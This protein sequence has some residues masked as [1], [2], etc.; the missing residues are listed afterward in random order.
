[1]V[2]HSAVQASAWGTPTLAHIMTKL[3]RHAEH[4]EVEGFMV[5]GT[6]RI[7]MS[8]PYQHSQADV[9]VICLEG[10]LVAGGLATAVAWMC[11]LEVGP[12]GPGSSHLEDP[13]RSRI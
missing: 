10:R 6:V 1:M 12:P 9:A 13:G 4:S 8:M 11:S 2:L 5:R 7:P 3:T